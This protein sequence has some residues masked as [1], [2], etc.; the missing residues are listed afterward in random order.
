MGNN[1]NDDNNE[2]DDMISEAIDQLASDNVAEGAGALV[3]IARYM[4]KAGIPRES[5]LNIR[6]YIIQSAKRRDQCPK[7]IDMKVK[8]A[9]RDAMI[10]R[11]SEQ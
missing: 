4:N 11:L 5:F 8:S 7:L 10:N 9:E 2:F 3:E 1:M 6:S